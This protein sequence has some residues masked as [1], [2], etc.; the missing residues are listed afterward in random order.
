MTAIA[1]TEPT[2]RLDA[3]TADA[4]LG[5]LAGKTL[6]ASV[7]LA[8]VRPP[9]ATGGVYRARGVMVRLQWNWREQERLCQE[10]LSDPDAADRTQAARAARLRVLIAEERSLL[11]RYRNRARP[12]AL[13][14][15]STP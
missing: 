9:Y 7:I 3:T 11:R 12:S 10:A 6:V 13:M 14:K 15:G 1:A 2:A 4:R 8:G 5:D